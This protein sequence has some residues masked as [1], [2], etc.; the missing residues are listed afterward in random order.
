[1]SFYVYILRCVDHSYYVG[2]T[3]NLEIRI[4]Q[5]EAGEIPGYTQT[6]RPVRLVFSDE[7][8]TRIE[9]L[10]AERQ[11]KGWS[12]AKKEALIMGNR[13]RVRLLAKTKKAKASAEDEALRL[14]LAPGSGR[15]VGGSDTIT[16]LS[17]PVEEPRPAPRSQNDHPGA[18]AEGSRPGPPPARSHSPTRS[19][20]VEA[21][22]SPPPATIP[23][24][25]N[26]TDR[27][28]VTIYTDGAC[29]GNPGRGGYGVV[30]MYGK[31]RL[32]V[33]A[34]YRKTTNN[35]MEMLAAII[36]LEG[37]KEP[38]SVTLFSD[39]RYLVDAISKGWA[40]RWRANGWMRNK[41]D[42]A[43]NPDLWER[44][45]K[46]CEKHAVDFQWVRG[47]NGN[48]ENERCDALATLAAA[49]NATKVDTVYEQSVGVKL[50]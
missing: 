41:D 32:E 21:H 8:A 3:D 15:T 27:K 16:V 45:L 30:M 18:R 22:R 49:R 48:R 6:R 36:G 39:S 24:T 14:R 33:S 47:H 40:K 9:A 12:R 42:R 20:L 43:L 11:I 19:K 29:I 5:H 7:F 13:D 10:E 17:E 37:L 34:G 1:M 46:L 31:H 26:P 50:L 4:A 23:R 44:L 2:H 28:H 35:R 25:P 38:C